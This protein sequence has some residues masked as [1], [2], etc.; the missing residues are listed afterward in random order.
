MRP[1]RRNKVSKYKSA[2]AF[3][4]NAKRTKMANMSPTPMRGGFRL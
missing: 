2:K 4:S 1:L 3:K